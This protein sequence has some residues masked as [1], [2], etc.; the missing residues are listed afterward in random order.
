[1]TVW[2]PCNLLFTLVSIV[3]P[4]SVAGIVA[5]AICLTTASEELTI[6]NVKFT[7]HDLGG[8]QQGTPIIPSFK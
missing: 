8:H 4:L 3:T 7:T 5:D 6:G 1:M 2:L